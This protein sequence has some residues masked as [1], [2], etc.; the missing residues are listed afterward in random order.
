MWLSFLA[1]SQPLLSHLR[2]PSGCSTAAGDTLVAAALGGAH[3]RAYASGAVE[4]DA[5][6]SLP[7]SRRHLYVVLDEMKTG[8]G[9]YRLDV[10]DLDGGDADAV[11]GMDTAGRASQQT[12]P[13]PC[14]L[15][16]PV[17][18][19][20]NSS[21]GSKANF[22]AV[23]SKIVVTG[24]TRPRCSCAILYFRVLMVYDT[25]M[26]KLDTEQP[27]PAGVNCH[28]HAVPVGN[29]LYMLDSGGG[30]PHYLCEQQAV[31]FAGGYYTQEDDETMFDVR[32]QI[33][34]WTWK[35]GP[36]LPSCSGDHNFCV[37]SY[38]VHPDRRTIFVSCGYFVGSTDN[39][40]FTFSLDT[41][42]G[43]KSTIQGD[44]S[45]P[46]HGHAYY[47]GHLDSW[48]GIRLVDDAENWGRPYLCSC[49]VPN[50]VDD[51]GDRPPRPMPAPEWRMC[52]EELSFLKG[53]SGRALVHT[54]RG[55]FCLVEAKPVVPLAKGTE[56]GQCNRCT[57]YHG[58]EHLLHVTMFCAK[59][60]K[61]GELVITPCRPGRSYLVPNYAG[62][63]A[64]NPPIAF[65][66]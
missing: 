40:P 10:D 41:E 59:H 37:L 38:A 9:I 2:R 22:A 60:G 5:A 17:L 19:L 62:D 39:T 63:A 56:P 57:M 14:R 51:D 25:K 12:M 53:A 44:W 11:A 66:M 6:S 47:D 8:H 35:N 16:E 31:E 7:S 18:R 3:P 43:A 30:S 21:V 54:G 1:R 27:P 15:P 20:G 28:S 33:T 50:L 4:D 34:D 46:F 42:H 65:W 52:K 29:K 32:G 23:G 58:Y 49:D 61:D 55:R 13:P 45:M 64:E 48:V 36:S 26:A 24:H